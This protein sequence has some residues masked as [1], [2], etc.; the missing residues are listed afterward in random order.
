MP[1]APQRAPTPKDTRK[2]RRGGKPDLLVFLQE[3]GPAHHHQGRDSHS[4]CPGHL[5]PGPTTMEAEAGAVH[6]LDHLS[7]PPDPVPVVTGP[8]HPHTN[9]LRGGAVLYP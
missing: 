7:L 6:V 9:P 4:W 5:D 2:R 8:L 1:L 3:V